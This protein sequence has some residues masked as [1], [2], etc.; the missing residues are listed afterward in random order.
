M[1]FDPGVGAGI[2]VDGRILKGSSNCAGEI[3][4]LKGFCSGK[5]L[6]DEAAIPVL[7]KR[8]RMS[9]SDETI[10]LADIEDLYTHNTTSVKDIVDEFI[11]VICNVVNNVNC[12][13]DAEQ[14]ILGGGITKLGHF[15]IEQL[16]KRLNSFPKKTP[17]IRYSDFGE[18]ISVYGGF[19]VCSEYLYQYI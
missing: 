16:N 7:M 19:A 12:V 14:I 11:E 3:G 17:V 8:I 9:L 1:C 2:I 6:E 13:I 18:E 5:Y 10:S 15:F 4:Y